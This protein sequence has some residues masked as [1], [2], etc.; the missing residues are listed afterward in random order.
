MFT[1]ITCPTCQHKFT[2]PEAAMGKRHSC[3]HC[4]ALFTAGKS[5][6]DAPA[7]VAMKLQSPAETP[8]NKTMLGETAPPIKY[9]C[10][11][12]KKPLESPSIEAGTKK[13]C[14][15]CGGRLQVPQP[16]PSASGPPLN[17]TLLA[18]D[19]SAPK[20][21][22]ITAQ[23]TYT[24]PSSAPAA[25]AAAPGQAPAAAPSIMPKVYLI[26]GIV[27]GGFIFLILLACVLTFATSGSAKAEREKYEQAQAELK[28][29]HEEIKDRE[30]KAKEESEAKAKY[31]EERRKLADEQERNRR[32]FEEEMRQIT[33]NNQLDAE[34]KAKLQRLKKDEEAKWEQARLENEFKLKELE[35]K[36]KQQSEDN[37]RQL[38]EAQN[39]VQTVVVPAPSYY[40]RYHPYYGWGYH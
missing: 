6:A 30:R 5:V 1:L 17:K 16:P 18:T 29:L 19:D 26:G 24:M 25:A 9:N 35:A 34:Q 32:R 13:P 7:E 38:R 27:G 14:P 40:Y 28:K 39:R 21:S 12:C 3:P 22:G 36:L 37:A 4:Q 23:P 10:P 31:D 2:V 33:L 8:M 15:F 20:P 11:R